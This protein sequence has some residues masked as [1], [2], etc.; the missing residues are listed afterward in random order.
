MN[1]RDQWKIKSQ[2]IHWPHWLRFL[3]S[4]GQ[5]GVQKG[6]QTCWLCSKWFRNSW[7]LNRHMRIHTGEKPFAC[8]I[9]SYATN[10]K[11]SVLSHMKTKHGI[12]PSDGHLPEHGI[13]PWY[14]TWCTYD[15]EIWT[16][17]T[18]VVQHLFMHVHTIFC[19]LV[20]LSCQ[21]W[22]VGNITE[23]G[24][25]LSKLKLTVWYGAR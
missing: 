23:E 18:L 20:K 4:A 10:T 8:R 25:V 13:L 1:G 3:Y 9:C 14:G 11:S 6:G 16:L 22:G 24:L 5:K 7:F 15:Y 17:T 2:Y 21:W 19:P 12:L